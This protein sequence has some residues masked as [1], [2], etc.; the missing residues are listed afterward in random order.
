M[1][2]QSALNDDLAFI[3]NLSP[4]DVQSTET[5]DWQSIGKADRKQMIAAFIESTPKTTS[6]QIAQLTK[7]SPTRVRE[8]LQELV[9]DG[10]IEKIG[11]YRYASYTIKNKDE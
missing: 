5:V 8:L 3:T 4:I 7:L 1:P 11:N 9:A 2:A 6:S 10:V